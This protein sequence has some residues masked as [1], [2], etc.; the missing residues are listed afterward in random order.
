MSKPGFDNDGLPLNAT[1]AKREI[2]RIRG[3]RGHI[4]DYDEDQIRKTDEDFQKDYRRRALIHREVYARYTKTSVAEQLYSSRF[5]LIYELLQ[6][7]DDACYTE[8]VEPTITFRIKPTELIIESNERGF[9]LKDVE[10]IC[11][12]GKSSK[13]GDSNTTGEKGLGFKS[14]FG[15]ADYV[16]IQSG[17]WS[18]R[19]E[20]KRGED[21]VGM[22]TPMW[23]NILSS[24]PSNVGT[25]CTLRYSDSRDS[26]HKRLISEFEKLPKT[27]IFA[28]RQ[29]RKLSVVVETDD[30][31]SS[32]ITFTKD[33][34]LNSDEMHINTIVTGQFGD[35]L[36]EI[37]RLRLFQETVIDL[38]FES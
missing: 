1:A 32:G 33:G 20:H 37:T 5:R 16:H 9:S 7:G 12:T 23:T 14:V 8:N 15:I 13:I 3:D 34:D 4:D 21:G 6:N 24:L 17:L 10:S 28:L 18:F 22:I 11:D 30:G 35:H 27:I 38:P 19:F 36:S 31:R 29:L 26:F 2:N 25:R